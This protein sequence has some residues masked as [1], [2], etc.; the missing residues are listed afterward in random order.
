MTIKITPARKASTF[1][2][3]RIQKLK[4]RERQILLMH[5]LGAPL[6]KI[7]HAFGVSADTVNKTLM[8]NQVNLKARKLAIKMR[9]LDIV[10]AL[11]TQ[12]VS[13]VSREYG[14]SEYTIREIGKQHARRAR[15]LQISDVQQNDAASPTT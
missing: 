10:E 6:E 5:Q 9:N 8:R 15:R 11:K 13:D 14:L 4:A 3:Q 7:T 2:S 12:T 1:Q